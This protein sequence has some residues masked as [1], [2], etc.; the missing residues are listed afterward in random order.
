MKKWKPNKSTMPVLYFDFSTAT[1]IVDL[2]PLRK[3]Y[4]SGLGPCGRKAAIDTL[5][6]GLAIAQDEYHKDFSN[7]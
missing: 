2:A 1:W 4:K 3:C 7:E 5:K 6:R